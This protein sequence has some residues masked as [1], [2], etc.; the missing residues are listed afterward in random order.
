MTVAPL[1]PIR[2]GNSLIDGWTRR[3]IPWRELNL[4]NAWIDPGPSPMG[5]PG[6]YLKACRM[7]PDNLLCPHPDETVHRIYPRRPDVQPEMRGGVW[8]WIS[9]EA[10]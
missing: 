4:A 2:A 10:G 1:T 9:K 6:P 8:Y 3:G 5:N 7:D